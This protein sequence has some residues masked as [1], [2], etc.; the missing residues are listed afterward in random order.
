MLL[1]KSLSKSKSLVTETCVEPPCKKFASEMLYLID[2]TADPCKNFYK[3][4]CDDSKPHEV[5][6]FDTVYQ[7]VLDFM[8][9]NTNNYSRQLREFHSSCVNYHT[10]ISF[11]NLRSIGRY[12]NQK[13][14]K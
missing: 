7:D 5:Y 1:N 2:H 9:H 12:I 6:Y 3:Y 11:V 4:S 10:N 14:V 8:K 13:Y